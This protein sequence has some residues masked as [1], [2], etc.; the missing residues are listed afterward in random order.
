MPEYSP[1]SWLTWEEICQ[2]VTSRRASDAPWKRQMQA[3]KQQYN[4]DYIIPLPEVKG[5]PETQGLSP[6]LVSSAID[7]NALRAASQSAQIFCPATD[8]TLKGAVKRAATRQRAIAAGWSESKMPMILRRYYR[9]YSGYGT[10]AMIVQP[11]FK[12]GLA[13]YAL[14]DP[15]GT[16]TD[17]RAAEDVCP[18]ENVAFV[19]LQTASW[20]A[21]KYRY[22]FDGNDLGSY[23]KQQTLSGNM[24]EV[25][26]WIDGDQIAVGLIGTANAQYAKYYVG[27]D[28]GPGT[29]LSQDAN[30]LGVAPIAVGSAVTLDRI[31]ASVFK[32]LPIAGWLDKITSLETIA[33]EDAVFPDMYAIG[34]D[35]QLPKMNGKWQRGATGNINLIEGSAVGLLQRNVGP[36]T[37]TI[38]SNLERAGRM[39]SGDPGMFNGELTGSLR[40]GQTVNSLA[41]M[42]VDPRIAEMH[43][44]AEVTLEQISRHWVNAQKAW[45]GSKKISLYSRNSGDM[46]EVTF[47]P[48]EDFDS[49]AVSVMFPFPGADESQ[50]T[51]GTAQMVGAGMM[52]LRRAMT[53]H[54]WIGDAEAEMHQLQVE[55]LQ[56]AIESAYEQ[57]TATGSIPISDAA[58]VYELVSGGRSMIEAIQQAQKEAQERQASQA[59]PP[60]P[61]QGAAPETQPGLSLPGQGVE[62]QPPPTIGPPPDSLQNLQAAF[63]ALRQ[64]APVR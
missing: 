32:L 55:G 16:Y 24:I 21:S 1:T 18:P 6:A 56:K 39:I 4:G 62:S 35:G 52:S 54:P 31:Q 45:F 51:V 63:H 15:L 34:R 38:M 46:D 5:S 7:N 22:D 17:P 2:I 11:D 43:Q 3:V 19:Y 50:V 9:H 48:N 42:S 28:S 49:D 64:P 13:R 27:G 41:G 25:V 36:S 26:E 37:Q 58:R 30:R 53:V 59:P 40:S 29:L 20:M 33:A 60:G 10:G 8:Q 44:V 47:T 57:Q 12:R 23:W 61:G 14:R